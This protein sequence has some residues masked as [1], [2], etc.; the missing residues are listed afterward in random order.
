MISIIPLATATHV[1]FMPSF[2]VEIYHHV[3]AQLPPI[4]D[5]DSSVYTLVN[6]SETNSLLRSVS[7]SALLWRPH[8]RIRYKHSDE[9][10]EHE[11]RSKTGSNWRDLYVERR[12]LESQ[13][14]DTMK[15]VILGNTDSL[16]SADEEH[17]EYPAAWLQVVGKSTVELGMDIYDMLEILQGTAPRVLRGA[18]EEAELE[19]E[20][21]TSPWKS[22]ASCLKGLVLRHDAIRSWIRMK[23]N[24]EEMT[25]E[26]ALGGLSAFH[27]VSHV[28][29]GTTMSYVDLS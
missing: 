1:L 24:V 10:K 26:R 12:K 9:R 11:R 19:H 13:A 14:L 18:P 8:Y 27:G 6:C 5:S 22:W 29:V 23:E 15:Q 17:D 2:P 25:F 28:E 20:H 7:T 3:L 21:P 16:R 4:R